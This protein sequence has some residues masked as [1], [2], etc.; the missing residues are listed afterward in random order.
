MDFGGLAVGVSC[1][2]AFTEGLEAPHL[3]FDPASD[4]VS[5][6]SLPKRPAIVPGG[7]QGFVAGD[8]GRAVL[9]PR[10]AVLPD[11]DDRGSLAVFDGC[12]AAARVIGAVGSHSADLFAFRDLVQ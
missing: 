8:C 4:V 2:D 10:S 1:G 7:T 9:F 5:R 12:V 3:C 6:P 11:G